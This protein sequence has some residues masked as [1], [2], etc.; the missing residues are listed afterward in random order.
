[1]PC[2]NPGPFLDEA[3]AS[4]LA[5]PELLQLLVADGG[6]DEATLACLEAWGRRDPR[7]IWWTQADRGPADALNQAL[8]RAEAGLIGWLNA[9][10]RYEPGALKR[11]VAAL[12]QHPDWQMVYGDGQYINE[13]GSFLDFYPTRLPDIG[14]ETFQDGCFICQPTVLI[15]H[16]FLKQIGGFDPSWKACFDFDLWLRAFPAAP[17]AIGFVP[18]LQASTRLHPNTITAQQ[19]WRVNLESAALLLRACVTVPD[20]WLHRAALHWFSS[21]PESQDPE[22]LLEAAGLSEFSGL[23]PRLRRAFELLQGNQLSPFDSTGLPY[24]LQLLLHGRPDLVALGFH[25][26]EN[27]Q[28]FAQ[29]LLLHGLREYQGFGRGHAANN[30]VLAWLAECPEADELPRLSQAI[31]S[32]TKRHQRLWLLPE[33]AVSYQRWLQRHWRRLPQQNLPPYEALFGATRISRWLQGV[34]LSSRAE[35][36]PVVAPIA[37]GVNLIGYASHAGGIGEDIRCTAE[38]LRQMAVPISVVNF[39]PVALPGHIIDTVDDLLRPPSPRKTVLFCL[40]AEESIRYILCR[41]RSLLQQSYVIGYWPWELPRW[42]AA[43][44]PA[45]DLVDEIWV[46]SCHTRA[47]LAGITAKPVQLMP[48]CVDA[49]LLQLRCLST[50]QRQQLRLRWELPEHGV[51]ALC[52][53]DFSSSSQRKNP[54]GAIQAFQRAFPSASS[55]NNHNDVVLVVKTLPPV[56]PHLGWDQLKRQAALDP[57]IRIIETNLSRPMLSEL[58]GCCDVLVSLH[59]AEGFGRVLAEALQLGLDV[60]AT[61]WS[62]NTDFCHGPLAHPVP[63]SLVPVPAGAYPHWPDQHWAEPDLGAA[64][65]IFRQVVEQRRLRGTAVVAELAEPHRQR[66]SA[67]TCGQRFRQRL[68]QLEALSAPRERSAAAP[69]SNLPPPG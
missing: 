1:M 50:Q 52:S 51:V 13:H 45:L 35:P 17:Q 15:R 38:A 19:Q 53:F 61:D 32:S 30:P 68:E 46:A 26:P 14:I 40:T 63:Y 60:I 55:G 4:C 39:P 54:W 69:G 5:Q 8:A 47:A 3:L 64:A 36:A 2:L 48:L 34:G 24:E 7:L 62:G 65:R 41:G 58:Y 42:P 29:W 49:Q 6:S 67:L 43:Y 23:I 22:S 25:R 20:H 31:W 9:D 59:R 56:N 44:L 57:R 11:A 37:S 28:H 18:A 66:F 33:G 27:Q 12:E 10:D 16:S 21:T